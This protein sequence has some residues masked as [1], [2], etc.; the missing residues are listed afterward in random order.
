MKNSIVRFMAVLMAAMIILSGV[1]SLPGGAMAAQDTAEPGT[2]HAAYH[3][4]EGPGE[5]DTLP[6]EEPSSPQEGQPPAE[7]PAS[8]NEEG[9]YTEPSGEV[10]VTAVSGTVNIVGDVFVNMI[11]R[12]DSDE[13]FMNSSLEEYPLESH[14]PSYYDGTYRLRYLEGGDGKNYLVYRDSFLIVPEEEAKGYTV[15]LSDDSLTAFVSPAITV[16][17]THGKTGIVLLRENIGLDDV[18][19]FGSEPY[20]EDGILVVPLKSTDEITV[21]EL[22][23]DGRLAISADG[24][25]ENAAKIGIAW[26]THPSGTNWKANITDFSAE[27][28]SVGVD[29]DIWKMGFYLKLSL[30]FKLDFDITTTEASDG[31][32]TKKIAVMSIPVEVFNIEMAYNLQVKFNEVPVEVKGTLDTEFDYTLGLTG[33]DIKNFRNEVKIKELEVTDEDYYNRDFSFYIGTQ[34]RVQGGFITFEVNIVIKTVK[35]GPVLSLN[36]DSRGG[37]YFNGRFEKDLYAH[38]QESGRPE[39]HTCVYEGEKGCLSF[40]RREIYQQR[41]YFNIDL[42]FDDWDLDFTNTDE[43]TVA[44]KNFYDSLTFGSGLKEGV[45]PHRFFLVP[46]AVWMDDAMTL[47]AADMTVYVTASMDIEPSE[48]ALVTGVTDENGKTQLYLPYKKDYAYTLVASGIIDGQSAAGS[49]KMRH[50]IEPR[51]NEQVDIV[52]HSDA[53]VEIK[54]EL[55]WDVDAEGRDTPSA[56]QSILVYLYRRRAGTNEEW[57]EADEHCFIYRSSDWKIDTWNVPKFGFDGDG[58][59]LYEYRVRILDNEVEPNIVI[60]PETGKNYIHRGVGSYTDAAGNNVLAHTNKY[61][62]KYLDVPEEDS[63]YTIITATA[64]MDIRLDQ[65]WEI[66]ADK[67]PEH[68][69]LALVQK[70]AEGMEDKAAQHGVP[71]EWVLI[72]D[73]RKGPTESL[74]SLEAGDVIN[75]TDDVSII[76]NVPLAVAPA[77]SANGWSISYTVAKYHSGVPMQYMGCELDANVIKDTLKYEYDLS[78]DVSA[79]PFGEYRSIPGIANNT[80]DFTLV[81]SIFG[82]GPDRDTI[83]GTVRWEGLPY[84]DPTDYVV[85]HIK[86]DGEPIKDITLNKSDYGD[87][88]AWRWSL[89]DVNYD[90][91]AEY[92]VTETIP[93]GENGP[94]WVGV[95]YGLDVVNYPIVYESV[96]FEAQAIFDDQP[97]GVDSITVYAREKGSDENT[98][99]WL[100]TRSDSWTKL[101]NSIRRK[102]VKD[103]SMYEMVAPDIPGYV[104]VIQEPYAYTRPGWGNLFYNF[105]VRYMRQS[106]DLKLHIAKAWANTDDSTVYPDKVEIEVFRDDVKI[107]ETTLSYDGASWSTAVITCD[108]EGNSLRRLDENNRKYVYTLREKPVDGFSSSVA[109]TQDTKD[110]IYYTVTNTWVGSDYVNVRGTVSWEGDEGLTHLRP[111]TV[112]LSVINSRG[113]YEKTVTVSVAGDGTYEAV[114]LPGKDDQGL[115]L[116]YSVLESHVNGYTVTYTAPS[117]DEATRTWTCDV[118]NTLTGYYPITV[119]KVLRGYNDASLETFLFSVRPDTDVDNGILF[120][121]PFRTELTITGAGETKAEFLLDRDGLYLYLISETEGDNEGVAYDGT[122]KIVLIVRTT[123]SEGNIIFKSWIMESGAD[124]DGSLTD[125]DM[126]DT[127][128]FTNALTDVTIKKV[129]DVSPAD[130]DKPWRVQAAIQKKNGG[131]WETVQVV[132]L[133]EANG[134]QAMVAVEGFGDVGAQFRIRELDMDGNPVLDPKT[135][136]DVS[137]I[138]SVILRM[139]DEPDS[140]VACY[141]VSYQTDGS[142]YTI[143]NCNNKTY[144]VNKTWDIDLGDQDRPGSIQVVLQKKESMFSWKSVEILTLSPENGWS[145]QFRNVPLGY[146]NE[147]GTYVRYDYRIRELGPEDENAEEPASEEE[148]LAQADKRVVHA[149]FDLDKPFIA[150]MIK[151]ADPNNMWTFDYATKWITAQAGKVFIPEATV[152]FKI[153]EYTDMI[154]KTI[155]EHDTKYFVKYDHHSDTHT[156]DITDIAVLDVSIYKRWINF[157]DNETPESVHLMLVS[158]VQDEYAEAAGVEAVNIY[159]PVLT[160]VYGQRFDLF[161]VSGL[162]DQVA[163]GIKSVM[164]ESFVSA[165]VSGIVKMAVGKYTKLGLAVAEASGKDNNPLTRWRV[166]MGVKKY[167]GFGVPMEFAGT[168]LVTGLMEVALDAIIAELGLSISVPVMYNPNGGYWSIKGYALNLFKDYELTC[169]VINIKFHGDDDIDNVISGTK[170]WEGDDEDSRPDSVVLHVYVK[171]DN[172]KKEVT[173]S[174]VTV[175]KDDGW[176]WSLEIPLGEYVTV[177]K[178]GEESASIRKK[179]VVIEEEVPEGYTASYEGYDVTNTYSPE[180]TSVNVKAA[181][182]D[183]DDKDGIRP[184]YVRVKLLADG[185]D[186]GKTIT[187][188]GSQGWSGTFSDLDR[189]KGGRDITY[190][191]EEITDSV[192]TGTDGE[193][194]YAFVVTGSASSGFT[195]TNTHTPVTV[196]VSGSKTWDDDNDAAGKRPDKIVI[197]L[198]ADGKEITAKSVGASDGWRWNFTDLP[199]YSGGKEITYTV[200]ED[201]VEGYTSSVA[202]YDVTN[203]YT[204]GKTQVTVTKAWNDGDDADGIRPSYVTVKLLADGT[205][206]GKA[207]VLSEAAGWSGSFTGLDSQ[208]DGET[209]VYTAEEIT[210]SVITGTDGD[211]TYAFTVTGDYLMGYTVTN[212]H[213]PVNVNISGSKTW[214]DEDDSAGMRPDKI[215]IRLLADGEEVSVRTVTADDGWKWN[216]DNR[217]KYSGGKEIVYTITEDAVEGYTSSVSGYDVTNTYT[218]GKTQVNVTKVW[219]DG[220]DADGIRPGLVTV[221]LIADGEDTGKSLVLSDAAGWSGTFTDLD[222]KKDG[223]DIVYTVEELTDSVI[224]GTDGDGTY[225]FAVSGDASR[226]YTVTNTHTPV[227]TAVR[228]VKTWDDADNADGMRPDKIVIRLKADGKEI[229]FRTVTAADGWRWTFEDLPKYSEGKEIVYTITEDTVE[230]YTTKVDGYDVTNSYVPGKTQVSV[231]KV[232]DDGDDADGI[233]PAYVTARL[234]A[235]GTDTGKTLVLSRSEGWSGAF[236]DL[237]TKKDGSDIVYTVEELTDSVITGTDGERTYAFVVTGDAAAGFTIINTHTPGTVTISGHKTWDDADDFDGMRPD[238]IVIRLKADGKEISFRTVTAEDGW[239]WTF[240]DLPKYSEG[241]E[242][243]YTITEDTVEGYT[244]KVDGYDVTNSYTPGRTQVTVTKVWNDDDDRDEIRP[245]SITVKLIADGTDTGKTLVLTEAEGWSGTFTDLN[246]KKDG[247]DIVYTVEELTDSVITGTDGEGTYAF[248]VTGDASKGFTVINT[249]TPARITISGSKIWVDENDSAGIRPGSIVIRLRAGGEEVSVR[250]VTADDGW[251]WIFEDLPKYS[252]GKEIVYTITEDTVDDYTTSVEGFDVINTY[253]PGRTQVTVTKLWDDRDDAD[254]IRPEYVTVKLLANGTDTARALVLSEE[255]SWSGTFRDLDTR[256]DGADIVYTVEEVTDSVITGTDGEGTYAYAVTGDASKGFTI[257]NTHTPV[258]CTITYVLNGGSY[259]GSTDDIVERYS[260]GTVISIHPAPVRDGYVFTYWQGSEYH[261]GDTYTV[262]EDHVFTAQWREKTSPPNDP[263]TWLGSHM[264]LLMAM[265]SLSAAG[266]FLI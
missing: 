199:K 149:K 146:F 182:N 37:C 240:E 193:G 171:D 174:P 117:Y 175:T 63:L 109:I 200:T 224:T 228:G 254:G 161:D 134:W 32:E 52:I 60:T 19:V 244:T 151:I 180:K 46:A 2:A 56:S 77:N 265:I 45:C 197:R 39:V 257:I 232:W 35:I 211:G 95:S 245:D 217:P 69:Y 85:L 178:E 25:S 236:T 31:L 160:A 92:T 99:T 237:D 68:N 169:N 75:I 156:M 243:V 67:I 44:T 59:Y 205:D 5:D 137:N 247:A 252:E 18:L 209:I 96:Q 62:I 165:A 135:D 235:D 7:D 256:K 91:D 191:V 196:T 184:A 54:T 164:G 9:G 71:A 125:D 23:S 203:T 159:T 15:T 8:D 102:D 266:I 181:W 97:E 139:T 86:K 41:I 130:A 82:V 177:E 1:P 213:T 262:T 110:D 251:S 194:T 186:T 227:R 10:E 55:V 4:D 153:E 264:Y 132:D 238:K 166:V 48:R 226:G 53:T 20:T 58:S 108:T 38:G 76:G 111:A 81:A 11:N 188:S 170:Y 17:K 121:Q 120:P 162:S 49:K 144:K 87:S 173:G 218:P 22:F 239:R 155:P 136:G 40:E 107:A 12:D 190:T 13:T 207:M 29:V 234:L 141:E 142:V 249:H 34:L 198:K 118:K 72:M 123:D 119:R 3:S 204:P 79:E 208:K 168:E 36:Q 66:D 163:S 233:R 64:V 230:G 50:W 57:Q 133:N 261:P 263:K 89:K 90:P 150:N 255:G 70:P 195:V 258:M 51:A 222:T 112:Q 14:D 202:G 16:E 104:K 216:F 248:A 183:R 28:P 225:A 206:T 33:A 6:S 131:E 157:E 103:I 143:T 122:E 94:E 47:P 105:T 88:T 145:G 215:V 179:E 260:R 126:S 100:L 84:H 223:S 221:K 176:K 167:G 231:T 26:E 106:D 250:T 210:D 98:V 140:P 158:K 30:E 148:R 21:N 78:V 127:V 128:V 113:E 93:A 73:P 61:F 154:G 152:V 116:Y 242:I 114:H 214:E 229:S 27:W 138:P 43:Q 24:A 101:D 83:G 115:D 124:Y 147:T 189:K 253:A 259:G 129:W 74:N 192:I 172:S 212:I 219:N 187:V 220:D 185:E 241:K 65:H 201:T 246:T 42:F 80:N